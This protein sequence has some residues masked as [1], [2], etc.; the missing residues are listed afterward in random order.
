MIEAAVPALNLFRAGLPWTTPFERL[1]AFPPDSWGRV[2]HEYFSRRGMSFLPKYQHH[3]ALHVLLGYEAD[4]LGEIRLQA[5]MVG[6][7]SRTGAG[8][9]LYYL[10]VMLL[11]EHRTDM[12]CHL[13]RGR[14]SR[15]IDWLAIERD[16]A[17]PLREVRQ[18]WCLCEL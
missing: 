1:A 9:A 18:T 12:A 17:K 3:D 16:L 4:T 7:H 15:P 13:L 5:F 11:P 2:L 10:G 6:N 8:W 14:K